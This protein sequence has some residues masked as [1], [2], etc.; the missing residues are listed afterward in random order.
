MNHH[1]YALLI[2][3]SHYDPGD[4][5]FSSLQGP[6][7]DLTLFESWLTNPN[8][9]H[10]PRQNIATIQSTPHHGPNQYR[11]DDTLLRLI[12]QSNAVSNGQQR[13]FYFYYS[14]HGQTDPRGK[15]SDTALCLPSWT[16]IK[17]H[18]ALSALDYIEYL[19]SK[20]EFDETW[21]F[22]DCCRSKALSAE[23]FRPTLDATSP[24]NLTG[25]TFAA[26]A[27]GNFS[28]AFEDTTG[29][30]PTGK[31]TKVL[32]DGLNGGAL[33]PAGRITIDSL[34]SFLNTELPKISNQ[35]PSYH[36]SFT[37]PDS[38]V[39]LVDTSGTTPMGTV[40]VN[41]TAGADPQTIK[42]GILN[43]VFTF[44]PGDVGG[45]PSVQLPL[46]LYSVESAAPAKQPK[47]FS[48]RYDGEAI[49]V[50]F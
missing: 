41:L 14:G 35:T 38:Q 39:V 17:R 50:D 24:G 2:G 19:K 36:S 10:L 28:Q 6:P 45:S 37:L 43:T 16:T 30:K 34:K 49:D 48:I 31:F 32:V 33:D 7:N 5:G 25:E 42:D 47:T 9:G 20:T 21:M 44:D 12:K 13:R 29:P 1:D 23:G 26:Y 11:L 22:L 18:R 15:L 4:R 46:G 3:F 8:G 40:T 27:S